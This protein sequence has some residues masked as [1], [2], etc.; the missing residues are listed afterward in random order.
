MPR[1]KNPAAVELGKLGARAQRQKYTKAERS[2]QARRAVN[3]RRDR[4]KGPWY[5]LIVFPEDFAWKG[6]I[7]AAPVIDEMHADTVK[8]VFW[9]QNRAEVVAYT[10]K[11]EFE[12]RIT[13]IIEQGWDPRLFTIRREYQPDTES[14]L[15][16]MRVVL[17]CQG[18]ES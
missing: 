4:Q 16:V 18:G 6:T 3:S 5:G 17:D 7:Q 2:E 8:V 14:Q 12:D 10:Q 13:D 15:K 1:K 11:A 9:S